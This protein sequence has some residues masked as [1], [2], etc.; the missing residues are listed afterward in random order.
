MN[1]SKSDFHSLFILNLVLTQ[2]KSLN[3]KY[4][5]TCLADISVKT[6][7]YIIDKLKEEEIAS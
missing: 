6:Q 2:K 1:Y 3:L 5:G 4:Q 7:N